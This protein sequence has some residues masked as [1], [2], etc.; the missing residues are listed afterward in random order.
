MGKTWE[1]LTEPRPAP[2]QQPQKRGSVGKRNSPQASSADESANHPSNDSRDSPVDNGILITYPQAP[3][4]SKSRWNN[5]GSGTPNGA[6]PPPP[7]AQSN[8]QHV[9]YEFEFPSQLIGRLIGKG[10]RNLQ[11]MMKETGTQIGV[12]KQQS[13]PDHQ[14][15]LL[16]L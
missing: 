1:P 5:N 11:Q 15:S 4:V 6:T 12:R 13:R 3:S 7:P 10:G 2:R 14:V 8:H 9:V 16:V